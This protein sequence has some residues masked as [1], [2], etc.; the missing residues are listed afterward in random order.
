[1]VR[2]INSYAAELSSAPYLGDQKRESALIPVLGE[3][4]SR[5]ELRP[6]VLIMSSSCFMYEDQIMLYFLNGL[7]FDVIKYLVFKIS[8]VRWWLD[9][10]MLQKNMTCQNVNTC[11]C[12]NKFISE[13]YNNSWKSI[14]YLQISSLHRFKTILVCIFHHGGQ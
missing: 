12:V 4:H 14:R 10:S 11:V 5:H 9:L 2:V 6:C 13:T 3:K 8:N 7:H 1:M